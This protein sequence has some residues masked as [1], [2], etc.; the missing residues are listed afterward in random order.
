MNDLSGQTVKGYKLHELIGAGGFGA[1]YR[2]H[3]PVLKRDVAMKIILPE[4]A[5]HP[6]F[7]RRFE[8]EA[9]LVARLEHLHIVSLYDYWREPNGAYLIMRWLR[10]GS[11]RQML[12]AGPVSNDVTLRVLDQVAAALA[13]AHR[14]GVVHRDI[15]PD[16]ILFD[17][18]G[19]AYLADFGI[20]KDLRDAAYGDEGRKTRDEGLTGSPFY[21]APEQAQSKGISPQTDLYSL[22]IVLFEMLAGQPPF[23]GEQ[24]LTG[25]LLKHINEP[26]PSVLDYRPDLPQ[27]VDEVIQR[28]TAKDPASRHDSAINLAVDF[29]RA[30][31]GA[32]DTAEPATARPQATGSD[33]DDVDDMLVITKPLTPST[34][35]IVSDEAITNPY[36]GLQAFQEA[37]ADDFFGRDTLIER[38]LDRLRATDGDLSRFLAVI[39]PSGSGKSSVVRAGV[40]PALRRGALPGSDRWFVVDMV[41]GAD[42]FQELTNAL[43]G[44]AIDAPDALGDRLRADERGLLEAVDAILL[45][46]DSELVLVIDQFEEVFTM[47][48]R[49]DERALF[50][51]SL[52]TATTDPD[53]RLR[54]IIT[55]RA[56]YYD[57]PLLYPEFGELVR[58]RNEVVLP[59][60]PDDMRAAIIGP[61]ERVGVT[62]ETGLVAAIVADIAEQPGALPLMQYALTEVFERREG[63][64]LT[65]EAYQA[66]GGVLGALARRAEELYQAT[67]PEGQAAMRQIFLRL[68]AVH[69]GAEDTRRRV[70]ITELFSLS[71]D[72]DVINELLDLLGKYRLL[73]FDRD[74]ET[75]TPTVAVA[76]EAL[77]REWDRLRAWLDDNREDILLQR[78]LATAYEE[79]DRQ[80]RDPSF[81][82]SGM[83]LQQFEGLRDR[84]MIALTQEERDYIQAS[85][86]ERERQAAEERA[87]QEREA[88]LERRAQNVLRALAAVM[89]IAA[90]IGIALALIANN[91]RNEAEDQRTIAER[92]AEIS[93]SLRLA[94]SAQ[95][96]FIQQN[97]ALAIA[98]AIHA[99]EIPDPPNESRF[100]LAQAALTPGT[101]AVLNQGPI[102]TTVDYSPDGQYA[103]AGDLGNKIVL[104]DMTAYEQVRVFPPDDPE[105]DDIV[106]GHTGYLRVVRFTPDG[107]RL[108][109]GA[110]D[111]RLIV[112]DVESGTALNVYGPGDAETGAPG[113][114]DDVRDLVLFP[115][116]PTRVLTASDD[117][118]M[119]IWDT[120]QEATAGALVYQ[121]P[122]DDPETED[123]QEGHSERIR[124][125]AI[126][127]RAEWAVSASYDGTLIKWDLAAR[128]PLCVFEGHTDKISSVDISPDGTRVVSGGGPDATIRLWDAA[129]CSQITLL[130]AS[131][132]DWIKTVQFDSSG[133]L[134]LS[135]S[136]DNSVRLW[137]LDTLQE[138]FYYGGHANFVEEAT[139]SP[140]EQ[141]IL[142]ASGDGTLRLWDVR[143]GAEIRRFMGHVDQ[144]QDVVISPDGQT[145]LSG[146]Y[147][148][149]VRHW[150][151]AT[152]EQIGQFDQHED[153]TSVLIFSPD[154]QYAL[155][156][157]AR[158]SDAT[159]SDDNPL[160]LWDIETGEIVR[161]MFGHTEEIQSAAFH[162]GGQYLVTGSKD[163]TII[164]WDLES[165]ELLRQISDVYGDW[166]ETLAFNADGT[167]LLSG[168]DN[169]DPRAILWDTS[170]D[171]VDAWEP[172]WD[173]GAAHG[174]GVTAVRFSPDGATF[175]TSSKDSMILIWDMATGE[176]VQRLEEHTASVKDAYFTPDG[177]QVVSYG[178]DRTIRV[179]DVATG[180][181]VHQVTVDSAVESVSITPGAGAMLTGG[182]DTIL[183]LWD[184]T[185]MRLDELIEWAY[186]N[187]HVPELT[188]RQRDQYR[189]E[190]P[191]DAAG[192][193]PTGGEPG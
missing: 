48:G 57:R 180:L 142:S 173:S 34:L 108:V 188:C 176:V 84:G 40:I 106:E 175:L 128:E 190:P 154:G 13:T 112:W 164:I 78:R 145:A 124:E 148:T 131:R 143:N 51:N 155:S 86:E 39:G 23:K 166:V 182:P 136:D 126:D 14:R 160:W 65:L 12:K 83:R 4:Y 107:T 177:S 21:L 88:A 137:N 1:V 7:V 22:G 129:D 161:E 60:S 28:A 74:P 50:L 158:E 76:H 62:V 152:G 125:V 66:S 19:N 18:E 15:K 191:C 147:D 36:K 141:H 171:D 149:T 11:L 162:P 59:L 80:Q 77:I 82:A 26:I 169:A 32:A 69:E 120:T 56:D 6:D 189:I 130:D 25:I 97:T 178:E 134:L 31:Q 38:L 167:R 67:G 53:S 99:N 168:G 109:S 92:S 157:D 96:E 140:D 110:T 116:D 159:S 27:T 90:V 30:I 187:R 33:D 100:I 118:S 52:R 58:T 10:G 75:R 93:E 132:D 101:R 174:S 114:T 185:P 43:L 20:A 95:S 55:M 156:S 70:L 153:Y 41:P 68:V 183:R 139:F 115:D 61:A 119:I 105:T 127:P 24:G 102:V 71:E 186:T 54:V 113:H 9:Q 94:A 193:V 103:A 42:P 49:E 146:S 98:L 163:E 151:L 81:L 29:R 46:D 117:Y 3:Q 170:A 47:T 179:W 37:D 17:E 133:R 5:N 8:F 104:W 64:V 85:V 91:A 45:D 35:I 79:W 123:V 44:V 172:A 16:N 165:G 138:V 89:A 150:D 111:G 181:P 87:R 2:A 144:I 135:S 72:E 122:L 73:T 121:F 184:I 63:N 192:N